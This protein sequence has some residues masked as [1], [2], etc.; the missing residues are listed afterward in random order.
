MGIFKHLFLTAV[1]TIVL[2]APQEVSYI[3]Y[4]QTEDDLLRGVEMKPV[5]ARNAPH[6]EALYNHL[7]QLVNKITLGNDEMI[8]EQEMY[9]YRENGTLWKR[10]I[11][12][13][14]GNIKR[15]FVYGDEEMSAVFISLVFPHR[16]SADFDERTT[17][18]EY[19][20]D[21]RVWRYQ[22]LSLD[23]TALGQIEFDF[24]EEGLV[25]EERW[26][27]LLA[28]QTVR[29]FTYR[30]NPISRDYTM[31]ER[32][33]RGQEVSTVGIKL[34]QNFLTSGTAGGVEEIGFGN[35]L[36]ESSEIIEDI[37]LKKAEGWSPSD[38]IGHLA[39]PKL[40]SSPDLIYMKT[41][42]I[43]KVTLI[44][45]TEEYVRF[46]FTGDRDVL[47]LPLTGVS[48]IERRDGEVIYPVIYR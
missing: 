31:I 24:F 42:D 2:G 15:M 3:R 37:L 5:E 44:A 32:D 47:T 7:D 34:P 13:G 35:R 25:K 21:G 8:T 14:D 40:F 28:G 1:V 43:L 46:L 26:T 10:V 12:D 48:E 17:I 39:D 19:N 9:E 38:A 22:F 23:H 16:N 11:A 33:V 41:G 29:L 4:F 6:I 27:D 20:S 18:Y 36:E 45:V 30:F